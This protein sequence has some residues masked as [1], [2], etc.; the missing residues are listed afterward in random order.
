M[1][2]KAILNFLY[3]KAK[4]TNERNHDLCRDP[5]SYAQSATII[6]RLDD[7]DAGDALK[8]ESS[9]PDLLCVLRG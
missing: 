3:L 5:N 6:S 2:T 1:C 8:E 4:L 7:D 9:D